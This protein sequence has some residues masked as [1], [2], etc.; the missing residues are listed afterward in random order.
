MNRNGPPDP[1]PTNSPD[2][3]G[4]G[5][6]VGPQTP[7]SASTSMESDS[8]ATGQSPPPRGKNGIP[9]VFLI[10][11]AVVLLLVIAGLIGFAVTVG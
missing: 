1:D 5:A 9:A 2:I 10:A 6:P 4:G 7:D 3:D 8:A 11:L